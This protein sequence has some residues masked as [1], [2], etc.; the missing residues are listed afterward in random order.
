MK[1]D[2]TAESLVKE[3]KRLLKLRDESGLSNRQFDK[4]LYLIDY[5]YDH[6]YKEHKALFNQ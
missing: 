2:Y 5:W 4:L 3:Y 1:K 6:F